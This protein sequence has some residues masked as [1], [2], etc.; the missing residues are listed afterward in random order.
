MTDRSVSIKS[1][2]GDKSE[3]IDKR[4]R[5]TERCRRKAILAG[6]F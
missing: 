5:R 3:H 1:L 6:V 2:I 4:V